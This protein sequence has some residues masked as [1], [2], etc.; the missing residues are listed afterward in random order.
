MFTEGGG[1]GIAPPQP[2][3]ARGEGDFEVKKL[4]KVY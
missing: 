1:G 2:S 4:I 3:D